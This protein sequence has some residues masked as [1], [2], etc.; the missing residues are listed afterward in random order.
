[1]NCPYCDNPLPLQAAQCPSCGAT[2]PQTAGQAG[3]SS[4]VTRQKSPWLASVLSLFLFAGCGQIYNRQV[5]KG[6]LLIILCIICWSEDLGFILQIVG[7]IDA[8]RIAAKINGGR[9]VG[10][11]EWF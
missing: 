5:G 4:P 11:W 2:V 9:Q 7:G 6:I 10:K 3:A 8:Y 1:M